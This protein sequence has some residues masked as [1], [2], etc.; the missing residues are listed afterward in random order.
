MFL[1]H[2]IQNAFDVVAPIPIGGIAPLLSIAKRHLRPFSEHFAWIPGVPR[3]P[4]CR[5]FM[6]GRQHEVS[7]LSQRT[8]EEFR[9]RVASRITVREEDEGIAAYRSGA[10]GLPNRNVA[11]RDADMERIAVRP[12]G[13][14]PV[15][16]RKKGRARDARQEDKQTA[17]PSLPY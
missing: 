12:C 17:S 16:L 7:R 8:H 14:A 3:R 10:A 4:A 6:I 15:P 1:Q 5:I 11:P 9:L 2:G 13:D